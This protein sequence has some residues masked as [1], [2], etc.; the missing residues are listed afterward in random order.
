VAGISISGPA[1]R[2]VE[3][4][5]HSDVGRTVIAAADQLSQELGYHA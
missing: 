1:S 2:L 5:L 4:G 3:E